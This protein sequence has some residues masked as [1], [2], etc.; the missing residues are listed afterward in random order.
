[1]AETNKKLES[2]DSKMDDLNHKFDIMMDKLFVSK[3]GILGSAPVE[4]HQM[5]GS[6]S[7]M[8]MME[9]QENSSRLKQ[10]CC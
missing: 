9:P 8:R 5:D 6:S 7:K 1:M 10:C 2:T 3:D 4:A